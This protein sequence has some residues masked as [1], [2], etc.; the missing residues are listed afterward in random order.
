MVFLHAAQGTEG[1]RGALQDSPAL[2]VNGPNVVRWAQRLHALKQ[3]G[4]P[5]MR[6]MGLASGQVIERYET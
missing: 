6:D 1:V 2:Q 3:E 4:A 5:F